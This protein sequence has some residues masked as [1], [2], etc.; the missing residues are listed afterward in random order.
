MFSKAECITMKLGGVHDT[1]TRRHAA[2]VLR[3]L[4]GV[5]SVSVRQDAANVQFYPAKTTV[6]EL[7]AALTAAGFSI[8]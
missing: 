8:L 1:V 6:P 5:R 4:P 7:T 2:Q 3:G